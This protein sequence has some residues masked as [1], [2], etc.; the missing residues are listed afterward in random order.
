M[1][2]PVITDI[3]AK[4]VV[5]HGQA[6]VSRGEQLRAVRAAAQRIEE[7]TRKRIVLPALSKELGEDFAVTI[8]RGSLS[9]L[10]LHPDCPPAA[11]DY[12]GVFIESLNKASVEFM[13]SGVSTED[14]DEEEKKGVNRSLGARMQEILVE[15][16]GGIEYERKRREVADGFCITFVV[17]PE[18]VPTD[19]DVE[20]ED[21]QLS[22]TFIPESDRLFIQE[23]CQAAE[24]EAIARDL[25]SVDAEDGTPEISSGVEGGA[26]ALPEA[27][28]EATAVGDAGDDAGDADWVD[29]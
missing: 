7:K 15:E 26:E 2:S 22:L 11:Q 14:M 21:S 23:Q 16:F 1:S 10:A 20:D 27:D 24:D 4:S 6:R 28:P 5:V 8:R 13:R 3:T 29:A 9:D 18:I 19:D 17:D 12:A 25:K